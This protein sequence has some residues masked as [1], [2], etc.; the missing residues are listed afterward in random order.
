MTKGALKLIRAWAWLEGLLELVLLH[1]SSETNLRAIMLSSSVVFTGTREEIS[2]AYTKVASDACTN[3]MRN[4][5]I[6]DGSDVS[7]VFTG[8]WLIKVFISSATNLYTHMELGVC[9]GLFKLTSELIMSGRRC[10]K[11]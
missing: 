9:F 6:I 11:A 4:I 5:L 10:E 8:A 2:L 7:L 3:N 1:L